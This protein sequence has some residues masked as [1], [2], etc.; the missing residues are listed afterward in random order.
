M[1]FLRWV[2]ERAAPPRGMRYLTGAQMCQK[3]WARGSGNETDAGSPTGSKQSRKASS[4]SMRFSIRAATKL[5]WLQVFESPHL[6]DLAD[7]LSSTLCSRWPSLKQT[8]MVDRRPA[9]STVKPTSNAQRFITLLVQPA[10]VATAG[11]RSRFQVWCR[12]KVG[13]NADD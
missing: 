10:P 4:S 2:C 5:P 12:T 3:G 8:N 13:T 11:W 9:G 1:M 7:S 6:A